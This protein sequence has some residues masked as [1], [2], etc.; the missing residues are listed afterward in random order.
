D[1]DAI[2]IEP[3]TA[4]DTDPDLLALVRRAEELAGNPDPKLTALVDALTP[5][6]KKG[7]NAV[8]FCRY[9]ATAEHVRD[10]LRKA[11]PKLVIEAVTG[12]L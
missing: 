4:F 3:G 6:I 1:E 7:V 8:V 2:D 5:L 9:L 12:V 11:F 10:G